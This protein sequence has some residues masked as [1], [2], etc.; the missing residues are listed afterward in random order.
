[1]QS[2]VKVQACAR[3]LLARAATMTRVRLDFDAKIKTLIK[4]VEVVA[5]S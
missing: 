3:R 5:T 4:F 2:C 1:V